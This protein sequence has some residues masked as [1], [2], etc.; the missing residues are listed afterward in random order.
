[1]SGSPS[2]LKQHGEDIATVARYMPDNWPLPAIEPFTRDFFTSGRLLLQRCTTCS[3]IQHPPEEVCYKCQATA[4]DSVESS[5]RGEIYSFIVVHHPVSPLLKDRVPYGVALV[6]LSD[7]PDVRILGN[8]LDVPA[9]E[10][11]IGL[12]VQVTWEEVTDDQGEQLR[13]PQWQAAS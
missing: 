8:V 7:F 1:L 13:I 5:G 3:T 11:R 6:R 4:F 10:L 12:P 2:S 9:D